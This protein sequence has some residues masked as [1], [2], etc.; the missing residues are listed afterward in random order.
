LVLVRLLEISL[1]AHS[2]S[3]SGAIFNKRQLN[4]GSTA[5]KDDRARVRAGKARLPLSHAAS[6][7]LMPGVSRMWLTPRPNN[8]FAPRLSILRP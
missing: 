4:L 3:I 5:N 8:P 6:G 1:A 2:K 7:T